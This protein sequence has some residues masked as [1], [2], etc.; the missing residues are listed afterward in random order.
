VDAI[1]GRRTREV[2]VTIHLSVPPRRRDETPIKLS[3]D[4][5]GIDDLRPVVVR[6]GGQIDPPETGWG[7]RGYRPCDGVD[8]EG[9]VIQF[10][11]PLAPTA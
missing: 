5:A 3:F 10:R 9:N 8:P 11:E 7:F 4:V 1:A 6:L 2:A